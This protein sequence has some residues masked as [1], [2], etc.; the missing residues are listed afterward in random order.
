MA[1]EAGA[2]STPPAPAFGALDITLTMAANRPA[3]KVR[4]EDSPPACPITRASSRAA[5][6]P[7][8]GRRPRGRR[9][10]RDARGP[11][12]GNR[13]RRIEHEE[14][15][16]GRADAR[17]DPW[18]RRT[19]A[20]MPPMSV[21]R[22]RRPEFFFS[23]PPRVGNASPSPRPGRESAA[24][25]ARRGRGPPSG[26]C[27]RARPR[28]WPR[29]RDRHRE[30]PSLGRDR[31]GLQDD[32]VGPARAREVLVVGAGRVDQ[33]HLRPRPPNCAFSPSST[34]RALASSAVCHLSAAGPR[35]RG[36]RCSSPGMPRALH[37][38]YPFRSC[39]FLHPGDRQAHAGNR[40]DMDPADP[41]GQARGA[42]SPRPF[43]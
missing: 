5:L 22:G 12:F 13:G 9:G 4:R 3:V 37:P 26:A 7:G 30:A 32:G 29:P 6:P 36:G 27:S 19:L 39:D 10:S 8:R 42:R 34:R 16:G 33:G 24:A 25:L 18:P 40:E 28:T 15:S 43:P 11:G 38:R 2:S 23:R 1:R 17:P 41:E 21:V 31:L 20:T 14:A 35:A